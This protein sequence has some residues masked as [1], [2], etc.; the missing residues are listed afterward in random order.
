MLNIK[1]ALF[2]TALL[3]IGL[4]I[5]RMML[6]AEGRRLVDARFGLV[7]LLPLV[8]LLT[9][10]IWIYYGTVVV[11]MLVL[12]RSRAEAVG[13]FFLIAVT[14]PL[15]STSL[16]WGGTYLLKVDPLR[17]AS[18]G[19]IFALRFP[20]K[21][22]AN[23]SSGGW[24]F[25][26][27]FA[28]MIGLLLANTLRAGEQITA[29]M[30]LRTLLE[31]L[32][33]YVIPYYFVTRSFRSGMETRQGVAFIVMAG[34]LLAVVASFEMTRH[35]PLYQSIDTHLG[36]G[37]GLSKTMAV[38]GGMLRSPGPFQESTTFGVFLALTTIAMAAMRSLFRS[39]V[40]YH[41]AV[42]IGS[43]GTFATLA[44]NGW[45]GLAIG[46]V[47]IGLYRGRVGKTMALATA[48]VIA[49]GILSVTAPE[50]GMFGS[51][52]G[53][54]GHATSTADYRKLLFTSSIPVFKQSP[55]TGTGLDKLTNAL[56]STLRSRKL[57]VDFVNTYIYFALA[58]GIAGLVVFISFLWWP[59]ISVVTL[60]RPLMKAGANLE[61]AAAL[62]AC[63]GALSV[64]VFFTSFAERIPLFAVMFYALAR[65]A[66]AMLRQPR[67]KPAS[68]MQLRPS[69]AG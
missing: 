61:A 48:A 16:L 12:P 59:V 35:W 26:L 23:A 7:I 44:R 18:L 37:N 56:P 25:D 55:W 15:S 19:L 8:G 67:R 49:F 14:L 1:A 17:F 10:N 11:L 57:D 45:I 22:M 62:F 40:A 69:S 28:L 31:N 27:V 24:T 50:T 6:S 39:P 4:I 30:V 36:T 68:P 29:T 51:L 21:A 3:T 54:S 5:W 63:L 13:L 60:K 46:L 66:G 53:K 38:R 33:P 43:F 2:L 64:M 34:L 58:S 52:T 41:A 32:I 47:L 65:N 9:P 42:A 20:G